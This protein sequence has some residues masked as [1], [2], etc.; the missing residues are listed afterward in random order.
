MTETDVNKIVEAIKESRH[1]ETEKTK[2]IDWL[3]K[4]L[5]GVLVYLGMGMQKDIS[6][7]KT[8]VQKLTT[9]K[10]FNDK[11]MQ[12]LKDFTEKPRFTR[13]DFDSAILPLLNQ[14]NLN[15]TELN[16]RKATLNDFESRIVKLEYQSEH[17]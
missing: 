13:D 12:A 17:K 5:I 4:A 1:K 8:D 10:V 3:F 16:L 2:I 14:I 11:D 15:T 6:I 7:L 9:E